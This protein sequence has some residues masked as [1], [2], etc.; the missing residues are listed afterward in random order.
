M[1]AND[2][3]PIVTAHHFRASGC[4]EECPANDADAGRANVESAI[5]GI[6]R[7]LAFL[8]F[9]VFAMIEIGHLDFII[10]GITN[11]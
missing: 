2:R 10:A 6:G 4:A 11:A 5:G 8:E 1:R 7:H 3:R 9:V